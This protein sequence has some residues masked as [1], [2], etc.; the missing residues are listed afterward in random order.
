LT[1]AQQRLLMLL[2]RELLFATC[3]YILLLALLAAVARYG[4]ARLSLC[5]IRLPHGRY[6]LPKNYLFARGSNS[7]PLAPPLTALPC[8][9]LASR[10]RKKEGEMD[11]ILNHSDNYTTMSITSFGASTMP[12]DASARFQEKRTNDVSDIEGVRSGPKYKLYFDKPLLQQSDVEGSASGLANI[13]ISFC[14]LF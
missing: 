10:E 6:A 1:L 12:R 8:Q 14:S 13:Y 5:V 4:R 2:S 9:F 11:G 3:L 7:A